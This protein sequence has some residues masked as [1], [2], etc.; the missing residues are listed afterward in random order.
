MSRRK[1]CAQK[2]KDECLNSPECQFISGIGCRNNSYIPSPVQPG[3]DGCLPGQ[4]RNPDTGNCVQRNGKTGRAILLS[5]QHG[6]QKE[7]DGCPPEKIR[8]PR[9]GRC[10]KRHGV[11]GRE[12][13]E[14]KRLGIV[15]RPVEEPQE[16]GEDGCPPGKIRN[17]RSK[18]CVKRHGVIGR[19]IL[20]AR[21]TVQQ[22]VPPQRR[23][24]PAEVAG[25]A[26]RTSVSQPVQPPVAQQQAPSQRHT[27]P[28][29]EPIPK[30]KKHTNL[31]NAL[32]RFQK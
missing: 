6:G 27:P 30:P 14:A 2:I 10:V 5:R 1:Y 9:S 3:E 24:S 8:N 7:E 13:L 11:I 23:V 12:I 18:R 29:L 17:P 16:P 32:F 26:L 25:E 22:R 15:L 31:P 21:R 28:P 19:E 4:I 20:E